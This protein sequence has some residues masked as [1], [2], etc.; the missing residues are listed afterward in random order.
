VNAASN[1]VAPQLVF[2]VSV[3]DDNTRVD[4]VDYVRY[5]RPGTGTRAWI[6]IKVYKNDFA[7]NLN[8][9][10]RWWAGW[11]RR[12]RINGHFVDE[13]ELSHESTGSYGDKLDINLPTA[14]VFHVDVAT[15]VWPCPPP[16]DYPSTL[17]LDMEAVRQI[18][19][20]DLR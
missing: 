17:D 7:Q 1:H 15:L 11:V 19:V 20:D 14:V 8:G 16:A 13:G 3:S 4:Y 2:E 9:V 18:I 6:A 10:H 12:R 5:F